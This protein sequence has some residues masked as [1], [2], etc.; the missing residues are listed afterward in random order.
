MVGIFILFSLV[1]WYLIEWLK[2]VVEGFKLP[3]WAYRAG[4]LVTAL[5]GGILLAL[6]FKL[7][8]FV[9]MSEVMGQGNIQ[10]TLTGQIFGGLVLASGSGGVYELLKAV[11]GGELVELEPVE[12]VAP[13]ID[14]KEIAAAIRDGLKEQQKPPEG[15]QTN[16]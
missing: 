13:A 3:D 16:D 11:K 7:D 2:K 8:V 5:A 10:S 9:M 6:Q 15:G 1:L 12:L 4:L 14:T